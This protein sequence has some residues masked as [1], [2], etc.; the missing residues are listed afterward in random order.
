MKSI[1]YRCEKCVEEGSY[2]G[3][4]VFPT[5]EIDPVC[6]VHKMALTPAPRPKKYR[7]W[8]WTPPEE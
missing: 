1:P 3:V 8:V 5:M 6:K 2:T 7:P 4:L